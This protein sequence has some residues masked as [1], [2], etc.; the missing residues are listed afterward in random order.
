MPVRSRACRSRASGRILDHLELNVSMVT[1]ALMGVDH[2]LSQTTAVVFAK[3]VWEMGLPPRPSAAQI[4]GGK[5]RPEVDLQVPA[6]APCL[7]H[8]G[9]KALLPKLC[10]AF[11]P[12]T[13]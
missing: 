10:Q 9:F 8:Y 3:L 7:P 2:T 5:L 11:K 13:D 1:V 12:N 6:K 4:P